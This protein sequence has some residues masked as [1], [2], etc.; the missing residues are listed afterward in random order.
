MEPLVR[1]RVK[2]AFHTYSVGNVIE[3]TATEAKRM[4]GLSWYGQNLVEPVVE[5]P[6]EPLLSSE[7]VPEPV[8]VPS[9]KRR[10]RFT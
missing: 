5:P 9:R 6:P 2:T 10:E 1:L 8:T 7:P 4:L 3:R